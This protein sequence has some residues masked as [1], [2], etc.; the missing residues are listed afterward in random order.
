MEFQIFELRQVLAGDIQHGGR[1]IQQV[2]FF[3]QGGQAGSQET[4]A[5][6][7]IRNRHFGMQISPG[8]GRI[9]YGFP[10]VASPQ[11]IPLTGNFFKISSRGVGSCHFFL[12]Y[13]KNTICLA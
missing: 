6:A 3:N 11:G 13:R 2:N 12:H 5:G 9:T 7:Y 10:K 4:C 1:A 8:D